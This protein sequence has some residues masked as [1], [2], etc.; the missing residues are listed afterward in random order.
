MVTVSRVG[1]VRAGLSRGM[2][3]YSCVR[4]GKREMVGWI[5][6][7]REMTRGENARKSEV[8]KMEKTIDK[9]EREGSERL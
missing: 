6:R 3:G 9:R 2:S 5:K 1:A 4:D 7:E 8:E